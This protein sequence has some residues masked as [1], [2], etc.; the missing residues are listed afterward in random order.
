[1]S[2]LILSWI[3]NTILGITHKRR[4]EYNTYTARGIVF[5]TASYSNFIS[6]YAKY[7]YVFHSFLTE[8]PSLLWYIHVQHIW[9]KCTPCAHIFLDLLVFGV[10]KCLRKFVLIREY[11]LITNNLKV[12][13]IAS[14]DILMYFSKV[15][16]WTN[17]L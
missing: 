2:I 3:E 16:T 10:E 6:V 12:I 17:F 14:Y 9:E 4:P 7:M 5:G 1:M 15:N 11:V 13:Y 8:F